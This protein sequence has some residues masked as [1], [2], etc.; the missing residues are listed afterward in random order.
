[1]TFASP[2]CPR[3]PRHVPVSAAL[4]LTLLVSACSGTISSDDESASDRGGGDESG[5]GGNKGGAAP[6]SGGTGGGTTAAC[7]PPEPR[8]RQLTPEQLQNAV[9]DL[10]PK[11]ASGP[12]ELS[13]HGPG[14]SGFRNDSNR[15][16]LNASDVQSQFGSLEKVANAVGK[17]PAQLDSCLPSGFNDDACLKKVVRELV[18]RAYRE[19]AA[20]DE[21]DDLVAFARTEGTE[22]GP[23]VGLS[24]LVTRVLMSPRFLFIS[25]LGIESNGQASLSSHEK[26]AGLA[27]GLTN[28]PPDEALRAA[29]D[30]GELD[31]PE[32]YRQQA[33]RLL[34]SK[35]AALGV[36]QLY[37]ELFRVGAIPGLVKDNVFPGFTNDIASDMARALE[38]FVEEV[39]WNDG[40]R[41]ETLL[42]APY[43]MANKRLAS[44]YDWPAQSSDAQ[45][46]RLARAAETRVGILG[47]AG[48][49]AYLSHTNQHDPIKRGRFVREALL[50]E[51]VP[52]PPKDLKV[53]PPIPGG[54]LTLREKL[55]QHAEDAGCAGCHD[56][57]DPIGF[58][59]EAFD[60]VGRYRTEDAGQP[61]DTSGQIK[62][63]FAS[64]GAFEG[65]PGLATHLAASRQVKDCFVRHAFRY[66]AGHTDSDAD[67]CLLGQLEKRFAS[68]AGDLLDLTTETLTAL[69]LAP[70]SSAKP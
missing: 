40:A 68:Q 1:M 64:D 26:A 18:S 62:H 28:R 63:S 16:L 66:F 4:T 12:L 39:L 54:N 13:S 22:H 65:L 10:F 35:T 58:S 41:L 37:A 45:F 24:Q 20:A 5:R 70:R 44:F 14:L 34:S 11:L 7:P 48:L 3:A 31:T 47:Q 29:A 23:A 46:N 25:E 52:D 36:R 56:R 27:F 55:K 43:A 49:L 51:E 30:A 8:I 42:T 6:P 67:R 69:A 59:L 33:R 60:G 21:V 2:L 61:V 50:C 19:P 9:E 38:A 17:A 32:G 15:K 57:M 53:V